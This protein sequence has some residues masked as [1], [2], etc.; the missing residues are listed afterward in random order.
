MQ[1]VKSPHFTDTG[2]KGRP[3]DLVVI[4]TMEMDE[5]GDT[6]ETCAKWFQNPTAKVSAH[7]CV[8]NN[9]EVMCVEEADVAWCAPGAN[10]NGVHIEHAGR[11]RQDKVGWSDVYSQTML[12]RSVIIGAGI[13]KRHSI[14]PT[15]LLAPD[16]VAQKRGITTHWQ[17]SRAFGLS[18]HWDPGVSFPIEEYVLD[19]KRVLGAIEADPLKDASQYPTLQTGDVGWKVKQA[20]RLLNHAHQ[21]IPADGKYGIWTFRA[22]VGFQKHVGLKP[23]GAIGVA[24]W[25]ALWAHRYLLGDE[26]PGH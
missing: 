1:I 22:V 8:D 7:Y 19:V 11:A 5:R 3:I 6:A 2:S 25:R 9:S 10:H 24:T 16:L 23:T 18:S 17:V 4:H 20:Q 15:F 21:N 12:D 26:R 14:P 13:C